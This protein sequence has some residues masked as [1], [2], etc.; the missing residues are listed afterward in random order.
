MLRICLGIALLVLTAVTAAL[1]SH[2]AT[3][4]TEIQPPEMRPFAETF[5]M[6]LQILQ[7]EVTLDSLGHLTGLWTVEGGRSGDL[8][9]VHLTHVG[10]LVVEN[11]V[12]R[13]DGSLNP[14]GYARASGAGWAGWFRLGCINCCPG[15]SWWDRGTFAVDQARRVLRLR[16]DSKKMDPDSCTLTEQPDVIHMDLRRVEFVRFAEIA[17]GKL[18]HVVAAP[19]V[20]GQ[21]AQYKAAVRLE[22]E[23]PDVGAAAIEAVARGPGGGV[24]FIPRTAELA[25]SKDYVTDRSGKHEFLFVVYN[26]QGQPLHIETKDIDIPA[27]PGIGR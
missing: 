24:H 19:Q 5:N 16:V 10:P 14:M 12:S 9:V 20:G 13:P 3:A 4:Q 11:S 2:P 18:I 21:A 1:L 23:V 27:I 26:A 6:E 22:W 25:G 15:H 17:P 8:D 7:Q